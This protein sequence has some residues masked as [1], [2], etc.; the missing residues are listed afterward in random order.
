MYNQ[1]SVHQYRAEALLWGAARSGAHADTVAAAAEEHLKARSRGEEG[2]GWEGGCAV[3]MQRLRLPP[4][5]HHPLL[6]CPASLLPACLPIVPESRRLRRSWTR[7]WP[8]RP[9]SWTVTWAAPRW[10]SCAPRWRQTTCWHPS[11]ACAGHGL[12][13]VL[14]PAP[15]GL[16]A[17]PLQLEAVLCSAAGR[18]LLAGSHP[19]ACAPHAPVSHPR[20]ALPLPPTHTHTTT[21]TAHRRRPREE[22]KDAKERQAAEE[23]ANKEAQKAAMARVTKDSAQVLPSVVLGP[24]LCVRMRVCCGSCASR[25]QAPAARTSTDS[26]PGASSPP[27]ALGPPTNPPPP[28]APAGRG[29]GL[30][31]GVRPHPGGAGAHEPGGCLQGDQADEAHGGWGRVGR[32]GVGWC[33]GCGG[34]LWRSRSHGCGGTGLPASAGLRSP[35][36]DVVQTFEPGSC[37]MSPPPPPPLAC[38]PSRTPQT[39]RARPRSSR[40]C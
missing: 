23:A 28:T 25:Q 27:R 31:G 4:C 30:Q 2:G 15:V 18:G 14:V 5:Y 13:W 36:L 12:C 37:H 19:G 20:A 32:V 40:A 35:E 10:R 26:C 16:V 7:R 11:S 22:I 6:T 9:P 8:T 17:L 39:P 29:G 21:T 3:R 33:G 34:P 24:G 38:R 1:A